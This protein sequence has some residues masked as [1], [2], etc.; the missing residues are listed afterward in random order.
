MREKNSKTYTLAI[1]TT[2]TICGVAICDSAKVLYESNLN[3]GLNHSVTLF[4]NI[5]DGVDRLKINFKDIKLIKVSSGPGSFTGI[6]I[7]IATAL[8]ISK[9][10]NTRIE[11]I[12]TLDALSHN[13][14]SNANYILS[15]IDARSDRVYLGFYEN[16]SYKK[17][18]NDLIININDLIMLLNKYFNNKN[19]LF[20]LVG[21][22]AVKYKDVFTNL[23]RIKFKISNVNNDLAAGSLILTKGVVSKEPIINY[24]LA[25]KAEREHND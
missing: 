7:G 10:Y 4:N 16:K 21:D 19:V 22:G 25:S 20:L 2:G 9:P 18:I 5:K 24:M 3:L 14:K 8:G 23:L 12:D 15:M 1:E 13:I 11:Y 17:I 6:R